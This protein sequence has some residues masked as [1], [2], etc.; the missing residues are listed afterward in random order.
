[1][2]EYYTVTM[3]LPDGKRKYFRG[4]T[5]EEAEKKR[6]EAKIQIG[7]GVSISDKTTVAD[8]ADLW[9]RLY[10]EGADLH[11]RSKETIRDTLDRY[12][13]PVLGGMQVSD[14]KPIHIQ[15]LMA[16][17]SKYSRSTQ[18]KVLQATR[19]I[20][21]VAV[22]NGIIAKTPISSQTKAGGAEP[23]EKEPLTEAQCGALLKAV[24]GTR[25]YPL[26]MLLN[27]SALRIGEALGLRWSDINFETGTVSV[28]RSLI[29][30]QSNRRGEINED[31]KTK[32]ARREI[33]LPWSVVDM[34]NSEKLKS[35][36][37][38]VFAK[39]DGGHHT[40]ASFRSLWDLVDRRCVSKRRVNGREVVSYPLGFTVHPH[41]LRH[42]CVTRWFE[43]GLDLKEVQ[44]LAG[45]ATVDITMK[46][47]THYRAKQRRVETAEKIRAAC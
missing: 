27:Y 17:V 40:Y 19:N 9:F 2:A 25:A 20:F 47:Y 41:L 21:D 12:I 39:Q 31:L 7:K 44:Y 13:L 3:T 43:Q 29:F 23:E 18:K 36:S 1:M 32:N 28:N 11:K 45:H 15:Q 46:I 6:E 16:S 33:P 8:M 26:V 37:V 35:N 5:K 38:W 10:K 24:E 42:T 30:P 22:D 14:V 34:L 4:K